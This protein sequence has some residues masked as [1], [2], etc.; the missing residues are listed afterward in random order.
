MEPSLNLEG[1]IV[2][3]VTPFSM[4]GNLDVDGFVD[5][6][7]WLSGRG[8]TGVVALGS[9]GEAPFLERGER[10]EIITAAADNR[11]EGT[12]LLAGTG[13][14]STRH[15]IGLAS[16]AAEAGAD[17]LLVVNPSFYR[18]AMT[19]GVLLDHYTAVADSSP[20]PVVLYTIPQN[21][22]LALSHDLVEEL[23]RHPNIVGLKESGGDLRDL[24]L[25]LERTP[26][27][28]SVITGAATIAG[29]A[30]AAGA[31]AAILAMANVV[32]E[33][34]VELF[35]AGR[36]GALDE[37]NDLQARLSFLTRSVQG[38]FGIAGMKVAVEL[39]GGMGGLPR[40]PLKPVTDEERSTIHAALVEGGVEIPAAAE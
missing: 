22:G 18:S 15:T 35:G 14:E 38:R 3:L 36:D 5:Q 37:M 24:L 40:A 26:P 1:V 12:L 27:G 7:T 31:S 33:L 39:L 34:C 17:A 11:E 2:P 30:A 13:V 23:S 25:H 32:P 9:T 8:L 28:F 10:R 19:P 6:L 4:D 29:H 21:T 20:L 16:D